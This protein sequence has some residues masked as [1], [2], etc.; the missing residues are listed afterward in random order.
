VTPDIETA[1]ATSPV[2]RLATI[3]SDGAPDVVPITFAIDGDVLYTA[4]DHKPKR[5]R[6][7]Q[8]LTNIERDPRVTVLVDHYDDDW[9]TL[10]WYRLR[11]EASVVTAGPDF[12]AGVTAL[13]EKYQHYRERP[14]AGP[15]VVVR[16]TNR[17]AWTAGTMSDA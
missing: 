10:W 1:V 9:T 11:G 13:R 6:R 8:R 2:A 16:I 5:T 7:L 3:G 17:R 4:V 12:D 15:V 14:P